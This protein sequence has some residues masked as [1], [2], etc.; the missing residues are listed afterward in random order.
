MTISK[1]PDNILYNS[2]PDPWRDDDDIG[3]CDEQKKGF[4]DY[5]IAEIT[6]VIKTKNFRN[7]Y[8]SLFDDILSYDIKERII[9][10]EKVLETFCS[11]YGV[12]FEQNI[13]ILSDDEINQVLDLIKFV[14]IDCVESLA[15]TIHIFTKNV[16]TTNLNDLL[17]TYRIPF[18][19]EYLKW[20]KEND[21]KVPGLFSYLC[22]TLQARELLGLTLGMISNNWSYIFPELRKMEILDELKE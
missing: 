6:K 2:E 20:L 7:T 11:K 8:L 15:K 3:T 17:E 14:E 19:K 22:G 10:A 5:C 1:T 16:K 12:Q 18:L 13:I 21:K 4:R 9:F